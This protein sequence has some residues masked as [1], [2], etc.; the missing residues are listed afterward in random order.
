MLKL[1]LTSF[2]ETTFDPLEN[3]LISHDERIRN[4][5]KEIVYAD[6]LGLDSFGIGE[7]HREDYA[8]TSP[9]V[10]LGAAAAVTKNIRLMSAV[11]VLSSADPVRIYENFATVD[12]ISNGRVEIMAGRG[13]FTESFPLFGY[14][15]EDYNELFDEKLGLLLE[16]VKGEP[17]TWSGKFRA[18]LTN[19]RVFPNSVQKPIPV[20]IASGG[21][22]ESAIRAGQLGL[23][24]VLA[25]IG[26]TFEH[27][28][29]AVQA[30]WHAGREA[31]QDLSKMRVA[32][33]SHGY[34]A[35]TYQQ[36]GDE[37]FESA[38]AIMNGIGKERGW[39]TYTRATFE[40][41]REQGVLFV[42][43]PQ[44]VTDKILKLKETLNIDEFLMHSPL[45][46]I[47]HDNMMHSLELYGKE[48]APVVREATKDEEAR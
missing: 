43:D 20:T 16:L 38:A 4:N 21:S 44:F 35:D 13:S 19:Q 47:P 11:T 17:V 23:P 34:I 46:S 39:A 6:E 14:S 7:H 3:K 48:V 27:F 15:L 28:A 31:G 8:A 29:Y 22:P 45:G 30:Y 25:I 32:V 2:V 26:G 40:R 24:L 36:A 10:I 42:G 9:E 18:P 5:I 41:A 37:F 12:A 1:G 33:H